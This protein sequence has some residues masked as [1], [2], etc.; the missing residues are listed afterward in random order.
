MPSVELLERAIVD[1]LKK[2]N[3]IFEYKCYE[4]GTSYIDGEFS[5]NELVEAIHR[6][7]EG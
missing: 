2:Q 3:I 7:I 5:I 1:F 6:L 4:E